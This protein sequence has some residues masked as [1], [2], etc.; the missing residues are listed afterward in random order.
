MATSELA[1]SQSPGSR[2]AVVVRIADP[3]EHAALTALY[4]EWGY[5]AGIG[6]GSTVYAALLN[7]ETVGLVRRTTE[8]GTTMLRGM[9]VHPAH[10]RRHV[11]EQLLTAFVADLPGV[12]CYCIPF[13]HLVSF[14]GRAGFA[15]I[16]E[17]ATP[18]F[19]VERMRQYRAE[20]HD[21]LPMRR[22]AR[23]V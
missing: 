11:G 20:G 7:G 22:A 2:P 3:A 17:G 23:S 13:A 10:R 16:S 8:E 4:R 6:P 5:R 14:Y 1:S 15:V 12:D 21:V 18:A 9:Y 19:L